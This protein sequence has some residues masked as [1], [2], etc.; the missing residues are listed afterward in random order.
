MAIKKHLDDNGLL[1][2]WGKL[3]TALGGKVDK[4]TGKGLSTEDY[5]STEK[6]KLSG[7]AD[8]ANN[9]VHPTTEGN[10]HIPAGGASGQF[11]KYSAPGAAEWNTPAAADVG[12]ADAEHDHGNITNDGKI[13]A[14]PDLPVFTGADGTVEARALS[15]ALSAL[16]RRRMRV[17]LSAAGWYRVGTVT[18]ALSTGAKICELVLGGE[19][20]SNATEASVCDICAGYSTGTIT[21]RSKNTTTLG[22]ITKVRIID[23]PSHESILIDVYYARSVS[24]GVVAIVIPK[25]GAFTSSNL[26]LISGAVTPIFELTL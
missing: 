18:Q 22:N 20:A 19:F 26:E 23:G 5:T 3:K 6:T 13:G 14:T 11:L 16:T 17:N 4:V 1:Y 10:K 9:Y 25:E 24:N 21:L 12:A 15:A 7:I 2:F 8:N